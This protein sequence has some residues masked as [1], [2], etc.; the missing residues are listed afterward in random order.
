MESRNLKRA[1]TATTMGW[2]KSREN[3]NKHLTNVSKTDRGEVDG[4]T[5]DL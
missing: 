5:D 1:C 4:L 2:D 3:V